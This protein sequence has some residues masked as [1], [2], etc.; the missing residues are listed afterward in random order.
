MRHMLSSTASALQTTNP[1]SYTVS[2]TTQ[3]SALRRFLSAQNLNFAHMPST[4]ST[5]RNIVVVPMSMTSWPANLTGGFG[6]QGVGGLGCQCFETLCPPPR[7]KQV[8][9]RISKNPANLALVFLPK[10]LRIVCAAVLQ[11]PVAVATA[12]FLFVQLPPSCNLEVL[13]KPQ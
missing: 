7:A 13:L 12:S 5:V 3:V 1:I 10:F 6:T 8:P 4:S 11:L 9:S 2:C